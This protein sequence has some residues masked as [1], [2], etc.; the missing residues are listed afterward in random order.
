MSKM[1][2]ILHIRNG[3]IVNKSDVKKLF[4]QLHDGKFLIEI[5]KHNKRSNPQNRYYWGLVIPL[6]KN[7]IKEM[8][9]ELTSEETHEFLKAKFNTS[10]LV[11]EATGQTEYLPRSTTILTKLAFS[12]YIQKIQQFAAEFLNIFIPDPGE[13]VEMFEHE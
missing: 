7:G 3:E 5:S 6:V 12:E 2:T 13:Q 9:T 10:E 11:N 4:D 8:G 1:F